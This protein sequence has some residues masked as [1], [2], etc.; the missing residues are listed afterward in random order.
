MKKLFVL[1][2]AL[3]VLASAGLAVTT[4]VSKDR[5]ATPAPDFTLT[6]FDGNAV[7]LSDFAGKPL[8]IKFWA[9]WC[10]IC[11][12]T[13]Q[14]TDTLAGQ[15]NDFAVITVVAPGVDGEKNA[16]SFQTWY[17]GLE[18]SNTKVLFDEGGQAMRA[19][20][21]RAFPTSA[22]ISADGALL[23]MK[24]GH[25]SAEEIR[26][27][28]AGEP[29]A[30]MPSAPASTMVPEPSAISPDTGAVKTIHVA[31]GCFWGVEEFM[32]R[33]PGV[34]NSESGYAN[35]NSDTVTYQEVCYNNTGHAETVRVT[36]DSGVVPLDVLLSTFFSIIDPTSVD[37]QGNDA[38]SQY[39]TGVFYTDEADLP[40]IQAVVAR[41][42]AKYADPIVTEVL[43]LSNF[44]L[45]EEYHQDYLQKNPNGYCHIDLTSARET[46][47]TNWINSQTY[48]VP[49][50]EE[51][52][53]RLTDIQYRVT[54]Q[55]DTEYAFSGEYFYNH[56]KGLYVDVVTGEPLF[57][58]TDKFDSGC[59]W[60][61]FVKPIIPDVVNEH[62]DASY[63]MVRTEVRS[64]A[65]DTHLG[66]VFPDGP[67]DRGGLRYC[68]NSASIRF[69][70]YD[71][72][73]QEG[74]GFLKSYID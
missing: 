66:H 8:Y 34:I 17:N 14:E 28:F 35:G 69:I 44:C 15:D 54:Q 57:T 31:G 24:I 26:A 13:L 11:L 59:G 33:I 55:N 12:S 41:E 6:D 65:G 49:T 32:A 18:Y 73:E 9:S 71:D 37:R 58:S 10:S 30:D 51:L 3:A 52:K 74:Y 16:E 67:Q 20:G 46:A 25:V 60:P 21:V 42:Q 23:G 36:Y 19:F 70:P 63:G 4:A 47:L 7:S 64:R 40:I 50:Q 48:T 38:G 68:I 56:E 29:V 53:A 45:A 61:S 72:M 62:T 1:L 27:T 2:I 43:P 22:F 5:E 39:R